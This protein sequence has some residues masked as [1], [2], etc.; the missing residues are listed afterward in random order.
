[1][2]FS[3]F[4]LMVLALLSATVSVQAQTLDSLNTVCY[5]SLENGDMATFDA[6]YPMLYDVYVQ[7]NDDLYEVVQTLKRIHDTDQSIRILLSDALRHKDDKKDLIPIIRQKMSRIDTENADLVTG[8]IDQYGW[9]GKDD[10]GED[11][12]ETLFLCIQHC[13]DSIIQNKYLPILKEAVDAGNA[14]PWHYAFLTDRVLMNQCKAQ[15][16]GTQTI[17]T[18]GR[19]LLVPL[20]NVRE[21][22][23]LRK[24]IGLGSLNA[25]MRS[26]GEHFSVEDYIK[27][28]SLI[29]ESF[30]RWYD[31]RKK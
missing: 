4:S 23:V 12:N 14:E 6:T 17:T 22:D 3:R 24:G 1:M 25:Y 16:Y 20:Q 27:E 19:T 2:I 31:N 15:V 7:E 18:N 9:L 26:F 8:I 21:V 28:E 11:G 29:N 5:R 30:Q 10:I 13:Q